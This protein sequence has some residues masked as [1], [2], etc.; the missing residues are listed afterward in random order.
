MADLPTNF[1]DDILS[2]SMGGKRRYKITR[3]DGS[4]EEVT[5][6]DISKYDQ[7]GSTFG[8]GDINKTNQAVNEKFDSEDVVNPML[9]TEPG[10][11]ADAYQTKLQFEEQNK[12]LNVRYNPETD[13]VEIFYNGVWNEW[14]QGAM[15][16]TDLIL[17]DYGD[18]KTSLSGGWQ[19]YAYIPSGASTS[20]KKLPTITK[21]SSNM[22]F[23]ITGGT[24]SK[25]VLGAL[26]AE[27]SIDLTNYKTLKISLSSI[28]GNGWFAIS[29]NKKDLY[30]EVKSGNLVTGVNTLDIST[31]QGEHYI[32]LSGGSTTS[33]TFVV[34]KVELIKL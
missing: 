13:M 31:I 29:K 19:P 2:A 34:E 14:K 28:S 4:S 16:I 8:A 18:E 30:D 3:L 21:N 12:N 27:N 33:C 7:V 15:Q 20:T 24:S 5:I 9:T 26:F 22:K 6:E 25:S 10:F 23:E 1:L 17:Y 32:V 11:A